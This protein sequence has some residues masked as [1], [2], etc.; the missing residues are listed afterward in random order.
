MRSYEER[1]E[2]RVL[3]TWF[4]FTPG[5]E[6]PDMLRDIDLQPDMTVDDVIRA[7]LRFDHALVQLYRGLL[8]RSV[9]SDVKDVFEEL[10]RFEER[11]ELE[12]TRN[13]LEIED[14]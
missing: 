14:A 7:A 3:D 1:A 6:M 8:E 9:S 12:L 11:E 5:D 13:A 4:K 2:G 10:L